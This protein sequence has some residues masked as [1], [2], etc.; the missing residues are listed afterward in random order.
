MQTDKH[1]VQEIDLDNIKNLGYEGKF[2]FGHPSQEMKVVFDTGSGTAWLFSEKCKEGQ[3]PLKNKKYHQSK[4]SDFSNNEGAGQILQYGKGKIA[5]QP[6]QDRACFSPGDNNCIDK[7]SFLTV[8]KAKDL[9]ALHGSGLIGM[10]PSPGKAAEFE[11][12]FHHGVPS[13]I[14]QLRNSSKFN[15]DFQPIFSIYLSNNLKEKGQITFGGYDL[16]KL[17]KKGATDKDILWVDQSR[18]EE[19]WASNLKGV[20]F[21]DDDLSQGY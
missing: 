16:K 5:G 4:S 13:F 12:P 2:W 7:L 20:K 18:N 17:A 1:G 9:E 8:V 11:D 21:G 3:C 10:S 14:A 6:S 19:Y 15:A